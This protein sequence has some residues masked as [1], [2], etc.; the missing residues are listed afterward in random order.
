MKQFSELNL[1][2]RMVSMFLF[3][4]SYTLLIT[5]LFVLPIS[6]DKGATLASCLS[7]GAT[8]YA[9]VVAYLLLDNWKEQHRANYLSGLGKELIASMKKL[10]RNILDLMAYHS[11]LSGFQN[12]HRQDRDNLILNIHK[13][14][15]KNIENIY[16]LLDDFMHEGL[17]YLSVLPN[18]QLNDILLKYHEEVS[19]LF[20]EISFEINSKGRVDTN[21]L[22]NFLERLNVN[23]I[24]IAN[25]YMAQIVSSIK[26]DSVI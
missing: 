11:N 2:R 16:I 23:F 13:E 19:N 14:I 21:T 20:E 17:F 3:V 9:A 18:E 24:D 26:K 22:M 4:F 10:H 1:F 5:I 25:K 12:T 8:L 15:P 7:I 6:M